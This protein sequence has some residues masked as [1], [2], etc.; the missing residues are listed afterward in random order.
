MP[1]DYINR[2]GT[3]NMRGFVL[4]QVGLVAGPSI[5]DIGHVVNCRGILLVHVQCMHAVRY[6]RPVTH[7]TSAYTRSSS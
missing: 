6:G 1:K 3:P 4:V 7:V 2:W 5:T